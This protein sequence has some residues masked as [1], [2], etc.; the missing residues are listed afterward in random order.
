MGNPGAGR[1]SELLWCR[2]RRINNCQIPIV[3][4][5]VSGRQSWFARSVRSAQATKMLTEVEKDGSSSQFTD[6]YDEY[7]RGHRPGTRDP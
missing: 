7:G 3:F 5:T 6:G 4:V 1:Y 2:G